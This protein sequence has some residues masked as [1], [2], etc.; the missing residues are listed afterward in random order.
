MNKEGRGMG[1][2]IGL[3]TIQKL[4]WDRI[5]VLVY[6]CHFFCGGGAD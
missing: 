3:G 2:D 1:L 6:L 4:W 5:G